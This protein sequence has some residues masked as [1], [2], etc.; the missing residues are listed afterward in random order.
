VLSYENLLTPAWFR[1][2][3]PTTP[4]LQDS[5]AFLSFQ[6]AMHYLIR[7]CQWQGKTLLLPAFYCEATVADFRKHGLQVVFC[8][9][10]RQRLDVDVDHFSQL[11]QEVQPDLV[12]LYHFFGKESRLYQDRSWL[13]DLKQD[14]WLITDGAHAWLEQHSVEFFTP[15]H[16]YIDST[17]KTCACMM[18]HLILPAGM[19][20]QPEGVS[21]WAVFRFQIRA[22]FAVK[23]VC[24]RL[25]T[26]WQLDWAATLADKL[27]GMHDDLIGSPV[28]AYAGFAWDAWW[29]AH[30]DIQA[31]AAYRQEVWQWYLDEFTD[32]IDAG[33]LQIF[34]MPD[35]ERA[36]CCF[37]FV[38]LN[39]ANQQDLLKTLQ[40]EGY[41]VD[42]LWRFQL[43]E[44]VSQEFRD[45]ASTVVVFPLTVNTRPGHVKAMAELMRTW[46]RTDIVSLAAREELPPC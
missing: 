35:H 8:D 18:A 40:G 45:W 14:A 36:R 46:Q 29:Y 28:K 12:L 37:F 30:M 2:H 19:T 16:V 4:V 38:K 26:F 15:R 39:M 22:L 42:V 41:W 44:G 24:L 1:R 6:D 11:L 5:Y 13:Q 32:L 7:T 3:V 17:R 27:Y 23:T 10:D 34:D 21:R 9:I 33:L 43:L 20:V 25:A 31:I